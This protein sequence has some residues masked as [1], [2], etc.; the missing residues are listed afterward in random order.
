M[1]E[2][3]K[4]FT[5]PADDVIIWRYLDLPKFIAMLQNNSLYFSRIDLLNDPM[6]GA[7]QRER[8]IQMANEAERN[9]KSELSNMIHHNLKAT[10]STTN[11]Y[12][13]PSTYV[14]CWSMAE[15]ESIGMWNQFVKG[16][17]IAIKSSFKRLKDVLSIDSHHTFMI[18][19]VNYLDYSS[20]LIPQDNLFNYITHKRIFYREEREIRAVNSLWSSKE[21][22]NITSHLWDEV[23]DGRFPG[24]K[25]YLETIREQKGIMFSPEEDEEAKNFQILTEEARRI[26][27]KEKSPSGLNIEVDLL[28]LIEAVYLAPDTPDWIAEVI[29]H[30]I[31]NAFGIKLPLFHS[32]VDQPV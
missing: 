30:L 27:I 10:Y 22:I 14:N 24:L 3:H 16:I 29:S 32:G 1:Y 19:I 18:G 15:F 8:L 9:G 13:L 7:I 11:D 20:E 23:E 31:Q 2:Q 5:E 12:L 21:F 4:S 26:I 17:G 28:N 6:E 25:P